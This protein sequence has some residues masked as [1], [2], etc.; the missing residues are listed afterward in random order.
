[1]LMIN[2]LVPR[3]ALTPWRR[4]SIHESSSPRTCQACVTPVYATAGLSGRGGM[5]KGMRTREAGHATTQYRQQ[6]KGVR[7]L[8]NGDHKPL[9]YLLHLVTCSIREHDPPRPYGSI[10]RRVPPPVRAPGFSKPLTRADRSPAYSCSPCLLPHK[11]VDR[12]PKQL[13]GCAAFRQPQHAAQVAA[14]EGFRRPRHR[15]FVSVVVVWRQ[16]LIP[17]MRRLPPERIDP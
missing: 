1:M 4:V 5:S 12:P 14:R 17:R 16:A 8:P 10:P 3:T 6:W 2:P 7:P 9:A 15:K 13:V 11:A